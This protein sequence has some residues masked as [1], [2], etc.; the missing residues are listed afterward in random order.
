MKTVTGTQDEVFEIMPGV[1]VKI[2]K[3]LNQD[4]SE[5]CLIPILN[6][7]YADTSRLLFER[8]QSRADGLQNDFLKRKGFSAGSFFFADTV[9]KASEILNTQN[10]HIIICGDLG[11]EKG[12]SLQWFLAKYHVQRIL[13]TWIIFDP[14]PTWQACSKAFM[15]MKNTVAYL[16]KPEDADKR[17]P[18]IAEILVDDIFNAWRRIQSW[19]WDVFERQI[20]AL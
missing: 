13:R 6:V 9:T 1:K 3:T 18:Q 2:Q 4:L 8:L 10:I 20:K 14:Q 16:E 12:V 19:S 17:I 7:L 11:H 5:F 15:Q